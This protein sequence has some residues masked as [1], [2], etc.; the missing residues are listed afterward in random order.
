MA[1][2]P[3]ELLGS[4]VSR[5]GASPQ[6]HDPVGEALGLLHV[7]GGQEH[8]LARMAKPFDQRP[9]A[10]A[11]R[12]VKPRG[13]LV[14]E[15]HLWIADQA[16][17]HVYPALLTAG[18]AP[19]PLV[20]LVRQAS[21][22][23]NRVEIGRPPEVPR[24]HRDCFPHRVDGVELGFLEHQPDPVAPVPSGV[25]R[26]G[27]E[28]RDLSSVASPVAFQDLDRGGLPRSVGAQ[29]AEDLA[30]IHAEADPVQALD[31]AV[32]SSASSLST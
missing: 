19:D 17:G 14:Q 7:V 25:R 32:R 21:G 6:D 23:D 29:E 5:N 9:H 31:P 20:R 8:R 18:Q 26:I 12:R 15:Q 22:H 16:D 30:V 11:G 1:Q 27:A 3:A 10:L 24:E 2:R 28:H 13:R 4:T